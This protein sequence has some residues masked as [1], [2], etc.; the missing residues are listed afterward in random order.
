MKE[1]FAYGLAA[2]MA[3]AFKRWP[4]T[5]LQPVSS[6]P[7][8]GALVLLMRSPKELGSCLSASRPR[9]VRK[10]WHLSSRGNSGKEKNAMF[11]HEPV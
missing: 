2:D 6:A 11:G 1:V 5:F 3:E 8:P 9:W 4:I 10:G 7:E